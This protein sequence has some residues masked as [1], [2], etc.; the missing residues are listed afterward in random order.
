MLRILT[1]VFL[2]AG[3]S[4]PAAAKMAEAPEG[5][6]AKGMLI[7]GGGIIVKPEYSGSDEYETKAL[8]FIAGEYRFNER[9]K[10]Y[11]RGISGGYAFAVTPRFS[12]GINARLR[13]ER[14]SGDDPLLFGLP[15]V[16]TTVEVGPFARFKITDTVSVGVTSGFDVGDGHDGTVVTGD[17]KWFKRVSRPLFVGLGAHVDFGDDDFMQ[18]YY[19]VPVALATPARAAFAP[20]GGIYE[21]GANAEATLFFTPKWFLR[22]DVGVSWLVGDAADSPLV[23]EDTQFRGILGLGRRFGGP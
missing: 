20:D 3:F 17:V 14:D 11:A 8:P 21:V 2:C 7:I 19:G 16:D 9:H 22:G 5:V 6:P 12:T 1:L 10:V 18:S 4:F 23:Q 13:F 15:D